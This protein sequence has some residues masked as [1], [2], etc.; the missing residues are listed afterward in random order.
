M[1]RRCQYELIFDLLQIMER[2]SH[3]TLKQIT[4]YA[5]MTEDT[6]RRPFRAIAS[7]KLALLSGLT[8]TDSAIITQRGLQ[9]LATFRNLQHLMRSGIP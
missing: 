1:K 4:E 6:A 3:L 5:H 8:P 2:E 7:A 9:Y